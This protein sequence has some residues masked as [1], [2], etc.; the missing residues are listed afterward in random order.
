MIGWTCGN[1]RLLFLLQAGHGLRPA[2]GIPC[3]L[4]DFEDAILQGSGANRAARTRSHI[5]P[6]HSSLARFTRAPDDDGGGAAVDCRSPESSD[7]P[8]TISAVEM[9]GD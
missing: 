5:L 3:A 9:H 8:H 1:C 4:Y 6:R 7:G 2:P